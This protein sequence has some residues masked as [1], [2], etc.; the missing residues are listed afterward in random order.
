MSCQ[1][2]VFPELREFCQ[3][4]GLSLAEVDLRWGVPIG[5][6]AETTIGTCLTEIDRCIQSN[7]QPFFVSL[8]GHR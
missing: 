2:Q 7:Y 1:F 3:S 8:L 4:H 5:S 6:E